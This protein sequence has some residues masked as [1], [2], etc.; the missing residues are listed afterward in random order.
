MSTAMMQPGAPGQ[1]PQD[2]DPQQSGC[3][4]ALALTG[5]GWPHVAAVAPCAAARRSVGRRSRPCDR[6]GWGPCP[7]SHSVCITHGI[8]RGLQA[9]AKPPSVPNSTTSRRLLRLS[10]RPLLPTP[11]KQLLVSMAQ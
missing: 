10:S 3:P 6:W 9:T 2:G 11:C 5:G 4:A 7:P 1:Q 8:Q